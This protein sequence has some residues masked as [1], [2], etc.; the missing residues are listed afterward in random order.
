MGN[1]NKL[2]QAVIYN[3]YLTINNLFSEKKSEPSDLFHPWEIATEH[4]GFLMPYYLISHCHALI[5]C[6]ISCTNTF[7][8]QQIENSRMIMSLWEKFYGKKMTIDTQTVLKLNNFNLAESENY[9]DE[10]NP[11]KEHILVYHILTNNVVGIDKILQCGADFKKKIFNK[12]ISNDY[13]IFYNYYSDIDMLLSFL[14]KQS[15]YSARLR[16]REENA[17][18]YLISLAGYIISMQ[19]V[20]EFNKYTLDKRFIYFKDLV[21]RTIEDKK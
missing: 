7:V 2:L 3:D 17:I 6:S 15:K 16:R 8:K 1:T 10:D 20:Y 14:G 19:R 13:Y 21:C 4:V 5:W 9:T 18:Y 11:S 12:D